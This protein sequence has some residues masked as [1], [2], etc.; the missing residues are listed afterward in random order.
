M[1]YPKAAFL[2]TQKGFKGSEGLNHG[3]RAG[4]VFREEQTL[5]FGGLDG[6]AWPRGEE[7]DIIAVSGEHGSGRQFREVWF[8]GGPAAF[9]KHKS[10][11]QGHNLHGGAIQGGGIV[12]VKLQTAVHESGGQSA[13][14]RIGGCGHDDALRCGSADSSVDDGQP[15]GLRTGETRHLLEENGAGHAHLRFDADK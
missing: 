13:F 11:R 10:E 6:V 1:N 9:A 12:G 14:T 15:I 7:A 4:A 3:L 2:Q 8:E 5:G